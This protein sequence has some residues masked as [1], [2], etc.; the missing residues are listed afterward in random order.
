MSVGSNFSVE[1]VSPLPW[2]PYSFQSP[3]SSQSSHNSFL[4]YLINFLFVSQNISRCVA[5]NISKSVSLLLLLLLPPYYSP[6]SNFYKVPLC[7]ISIICFYPSKYFWTY[8]TWYFEAV[9]SLSKKYLKSWCLSCPYLMLL[10]YPLLPS[11]SKKAKWSIKFT[12]FAILQP[13]SYCEA[14]LIC[15]D[16]M[17]YGISSSHSL[18]IDSVLLLFPTVWLSSRAIHRGPGL[19]AVFGSSED[20]TTVPGSYDHLQSWNLM[21]NKKITRNTSIWFSHCTFS[22]GRMVISRNDVFQ[23]DVNFTLLLFRSFLHLS[24]CFIDRRST[25]HNISSFIKISFR[26][27]IFFTKK[28]ILHTTSARKKGAYC[29]HISVSVFAFVSIG[30]KRE[31]CVFLIY[32]SL[33]FLG[34]ILPEKLW[35][36]FVLKTLSNFPNWLFAVL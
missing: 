35:R 16:C 19:P 11:A 17:H 13:C 21:L 2:P 4:S 30:L 26:K 32:C 1:P 33:P 12:S 25:P 10:F 22:L 7:H 5:Q 20:P 3:Y 27:G 15:V 18:C 23:F 34:H 28:S 8:F 9:F 36:M 31:T 6:V 29:K 24:L 14:N